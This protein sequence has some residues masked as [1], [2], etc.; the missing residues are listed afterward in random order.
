MFKKSIIY[1]IFLFSFFFTTYSQPQPS[2]KFNISVG[3]EP[4]GVFYDDTTHLFHIICK[5]TDKNFNGIFEPD[6]GDVRPSWWTVSIDDKMIPTVQKV[7]DFEF[8]SIQFPF[9]PAFVQ[10]ERKIFINHLNKIQAYSLD[11]FTPIENED[12]NYFATGL[13]YFNKN[14]VITKSS[15]SNQQDTLIILN[16]LT[17]TITYQRSIGINAQQ[18]LMLGTDAPNKFTLATLNIG[19]WNSDSSNVVY[20]YYENSTVSNLNEINIGNTGNHIS[21]FG[22]RF[23]VATAMFSNNIYIIDLINN[24]VKIANSQSSPW[25]GPSF[26]KIINFNTNEENSKQLNYLVSVNYD[27][28]LELWQIDNVTKEIISDTHNSIQIDGK[29]EAFDYFYSDFSGKTTVNILVANSLK[30]DY[31]PNNTLT[32][33]QFENTTSLVNNVNDKIVEIYPNPVTNKININFKNMQF[34]YKIYNSFGLEVASENNLFSLTQLDLTSLNT[35]I[36]I[37]EIISGKK[38]YFE[39]FELLK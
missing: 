26:S 18:T 34:S 13:D 19:P 29:G 33:M 38:C 24:S 15:L 9:R 36:Y 35:G 3:N 30:S 25:G 16:T 8:G 12:Y 21:T 20:G 1:S 2:V 39:K 37:I 6:S 27:G 28:F 4:V 7:L 14:L 11:L 22:N 17:K 10:N 31:S 23:L 5:G 32:F